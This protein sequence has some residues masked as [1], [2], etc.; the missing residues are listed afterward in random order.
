MKKSNVVIKSV[1]TQSAQKQTPSNFNISCQFRFRESDLYKLEELENWSDEKCLRLDQKLLR[2]RR[3]NSAARILR[4]ALRTE[5]NILPN[6]RS[7]CEL[8][9]IMFWRLIITQSTIQMFQ[10]TFLTATSR[11]STRKLLRSDKELL[12]NFYWI[13]DFTLQNLFWYFNSERF[14]K[15]EQRMTTNSLQWSES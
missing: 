11:L 15:H 2:H 13:F 3:L 4:S 7:F 1:D 14:S 10:T 5:W 8:F 9:T 12:G 6:V